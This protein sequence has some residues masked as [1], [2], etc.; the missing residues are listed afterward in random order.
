MSRNFLFINKKILFLLIFFAILTICGIW[1][2]ISINERNQLETLLK[3]VN[4]D[5]IEFKGRNYSIK[6]GK[7]AEKTDLLTS[8]KILRLAA[9]YIWNKEDPL[10]YSPDLDLDE[11]NKSVANLIHS[12][13]KFLSIV[14]RKDRVYPTEFLQSFSDTA[15][16]TFQF[17]KFPSTNLADNLLTSQYKTVSVY[18]DE[19]RKLLDIL[20]K[21]INKNPASFSEPTILFEVSFNPKTTILD[22]KKLTMNAQ[23]MRSEIANREKCLTNGVCRRPSENFNLIKNVNGHS[24]DKD[25]SILKKELVFSDIKSLKELNINTFKAKTLCYGWGENFTYPSYI[26]YYRED[27]LQ[28]D[29]R[30]ASDIY[31][32]KN[33]PQSINPRVKARLNNKIDYTMVKSG[34]PY[35]CFDHEYFAQIAEIDFFLSRNRPLFHLLDNNKYSNFINEARQIEERVFTSNYPSY[36]DLKVLASYYGYAYKIGS[37]EDP[38]KEELLNRKVSINNKLGNYYKILNYMNTTINSSFTLEWD[39]IDNL[40]EDKAIYLYRSFYGTMYLPFSPAVFRIQPGLSYV[41]KVYVKNATGINS[42]YMKYS[43]ANGNYSNYLISQWLLAPPIS[44]QK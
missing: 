44:I 18:E 24:Q 19:A 6:N 32:R 23:L 36:E 5:K 3:D 2:L 38:L 29:I 17:L 9:F 13:N 12:Q 30:L 39:K 35:I 43:Q 34:T 25:S 15:D 40:G 21:I 7:I 26:F 33:T 1:F 42:S 11:L 22:L 37:S 14:K 16:L 31:F 27:P 10:Y 41:D 4:I 8:I 28:I 20:E